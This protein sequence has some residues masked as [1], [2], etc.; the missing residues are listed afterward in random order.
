[1]FD[2]PCQVLCIVATSL[3]PVGSEIG[4]RLKINC[5][6]Y[7][8]LWMDA[9]VGMAQFI[10]PGIDKFIPQLKWRY[11]SHGR[12]RRCVCARAR[13]YGCD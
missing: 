7:V 5:F 4:V 2:C 1:M 3:L 13:V 11:V 6:R 8:R 10:S 9:E 12:K